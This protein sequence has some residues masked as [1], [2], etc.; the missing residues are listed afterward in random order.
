MSAT[1]LKRLVLYSVVALSPAVL[2]AQTMQAPA[3]P[4]P[5]TKSTNTQSDS[6]PQQK[7][8]AAC[9]KQPVA[10][11]ESCRSKVEQ[12][13]NSKKSSPGTSPQGSE[14]STK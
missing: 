10:D 6:T 9:D 13:Y 4:D 3:S 14:S 8:L 1:I 5:A 12:K 11:Q 2:S 7:E